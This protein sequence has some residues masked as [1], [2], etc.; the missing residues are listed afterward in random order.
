MP[1]FIK[2]TYLDNTE[3]WVNAAQIIAIE[4]AEN[5]T[6]VVL[7]GLSDSITVKETPAQIY[8]LIILA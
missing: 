2:L 4:G 7:V 1:K 6:D 5:L 3:V 8:H